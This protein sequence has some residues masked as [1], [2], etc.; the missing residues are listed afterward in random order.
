MGTAVVERATGAEVGGGGGRG[1]RDEEATTGSS[2][3]SPSS[4]GSLR[5]L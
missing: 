2:R 1:R 3:T 4:Q 5:A